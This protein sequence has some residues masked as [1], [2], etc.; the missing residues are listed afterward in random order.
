M[1][2]IMLAAIALLTLSLNGCGGG[3]SQVASSYTVNFSAETHGSLTGST[4][5]SVTQGASTS[6]VTALPVAGYHFVNWTGDN[7][8]A[9]S[10]MNPLTVTNVTA[11]QN[12]TANFAINPSSA[13]L[14]LSSAGSLTSGSSLSGISVKVQFPAGVTVSTD[15][16]NVVSAGV[17]TPSGVAAASTVTLALY[18]P[19][20]TTTPST[21]EFVVVSSSAGG[22]GVGEFATINCVIASGSFP[23][24]NDFI[25]PATDFKP[26]DLLLQ[27]I[28]GLTASLTATIN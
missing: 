27:P 2:K 11:S 7:G 4:S 8:F 12:I 18:T 23:M 21:L 13:V 15:T 26:A 24:P 1:K 5:Q 28:M 22:F 16:N 17:V 25:I 9:T 10:T 3:G 20:T 6:T 19:A 14:K